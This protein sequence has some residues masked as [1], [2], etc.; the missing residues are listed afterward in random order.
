LPGVGE[1][2]SEV[3]AILAREYR[4]LPPL[5]DLALL[6][7]LLLLVL[8]K[9]APP[10]RAQ[11]AL[12]RLRRDFVDWNELR[13]SPVFEI[14]RSLEPLE[15]G[16]VGPKAERVRKLVSRIF[17]KK[18]SLSLEWLKAEGTEEA[19][20]FLESLEVLDAY[21]VHAFLLSL[22]EK[23]ELAFHQNMSRVLQ[24]IGIVSR[25][26]SPSKALEGI[27]SIAPEEDLASFQAVLVRLGEELCGPKVVQCERCKVLTLC[28]YGRSRG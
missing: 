7:R 16:N 21:M 26:G 14:Q 5:R 17:E 8:A 25:T 19:E 22:R 6:D 24:R 10:Q 28:K 13:V 3:F 4:K 15:E 9:D 18:N 11:G 20:R 23:E 27:R 12:D 2:A 1:K